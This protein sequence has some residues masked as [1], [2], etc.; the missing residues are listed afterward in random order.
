MKHAKIDAAAVHGYTFLLLTPFSFVT[1]L[2]KNDWWVVTVLKNIES[3]PG[4]PFLKSTGCH[5]LTEPSFRVIA[6]WN[7][8]QQTKSELSIIKTALISE[9]IVRSEGEVN[10]CVGSITMGWRKVL[11][12]NVNR[13]GAKG[14]GGLNIALACLANAWKQFARTGRP[15]ETREGRGSAC[16]REEKNYFPPPCNG[17]QDSLGFSIPRHGF[18]ISELDCRICQ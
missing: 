9:S 2:K 12:N 3:A 10:L 11:R 17:I 7:N 18:R 13:Q 8:K 5:W 16:P 4:K 14:R 1:L 15:I 6:A